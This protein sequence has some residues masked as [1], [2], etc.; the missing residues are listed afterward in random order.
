MDDNAQPLSVVARTELNV[1]R[2]PVVIPLLVVV[3]LPLL[4]GCG[5]DRP[6]E[7]R[8]LDQFTAHLDDRIPALMTRYSIPGVS[9]ALVQRGET[10]WTAAYGYADPERGRPM[11]PGTVC[12]A[13]SISKSVTAWGVLKLVAQGR[14]GLDDPVTAHLPRWDFPETRFSAEAV[15]IRQ[16][17]SHTAGLPLGA[18]GAHFSPADDIPSLRE[19]LSGDAARVIREAGS[20]FSY[21]NTGFALLELLI[22]EVTGRTFA[23]YM[24]VEVLTPLG[25][26]NS[27]FSW[28][29]AWD[30]PVPVGHDLEGSAFRSTFT[31]PTLVVGCSPR[32]RIWLVSWLPA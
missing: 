13:H 16:V 24:E 2:S 15:T 17:L 4:A 3:S 27:S 28:N 21:S 19:A 14:I 8:P 22:E 1:A 12:M 26:H 5:A 30:P 18:L 23:E 6:D 10:I 20:S 29:V 32:W 25:M 11:T 7:G 9:I 31:P